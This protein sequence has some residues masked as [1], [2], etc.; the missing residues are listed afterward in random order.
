MAG[1]LQRIADISV[2]VFVVS[3][4]LT[5]GLSQPLTEVIAPLRKPLPVAL[6]LVVNFA[7][8]PLLA[9]VLC[10]LV[11]LQPAHASGIVLAGAAAGAPFLPKLAMIA[12]GNAAYSVALM[13]L[14]MAGTIVF[15][16]LALPLMLPGVSAQPWAIA[17]P[18]IITMVLPLIAGFAIALSAVPWKARLLTFARA[19]SNATFLLLIVLMI[20]LNFRT[21]ASALGS[22]AI[23]TYALYLLMLVGVGYL[24]GAVDKSTQT[25]FA[26]GAAGKNVPAALVVAGASLN[27]PAI[28]SMLIIA[29][30][31]N[32]VVLLGLARLMRPQGHVTASE[33][34]VT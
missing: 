15:M 12:R 17:Q 33:R 8:A 1:T 24:V 11:P 14:L 19:L 4:M 32:L 28:T 5:M 23:G 20:G 18:L 21:I 30:V 27:D 7:V 9:V 34:L 16:P 6:A 2:F 13:V 22:F 26:L 3:T 10:R 31:I 25:V 29:F